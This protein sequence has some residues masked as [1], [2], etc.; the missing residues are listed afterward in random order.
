MTTHQR[1]DDA[2]E[3]A[4]SMIEDPNEE[5]D[6]TDFFRRAVESCKKMAHAW[7]SRQ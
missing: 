7:K 3:T 1:A 5:I 2:D 6:C 4:I